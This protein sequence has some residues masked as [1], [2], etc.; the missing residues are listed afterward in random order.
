MKLLSWLEQWAMWQVVSTCVG[1][2]ILGLI[3]LAF[4]ICVI[5]C[6][7][8]ERVSRNKQRKKHKELEKW[9]KN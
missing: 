2:G 4:I 8:A 1:L 5:Y 7:I 6:L 9:T 3:I